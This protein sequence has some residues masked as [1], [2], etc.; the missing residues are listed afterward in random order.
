MKRYLFIVLAAVISSSAI[1]SAQ[2]LPTIKTS[3]DFDKMKKLV[4]DWKGKMK[5]P[6]GKTIDVS[7]SYKVIS[8]GS[9]LLENS[10]ED[11][12]DMLTT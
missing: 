3:A 8:N 10:V 6:D 4:G 9:V 5:K 2:D 12:T 1:S 11:G 7:V